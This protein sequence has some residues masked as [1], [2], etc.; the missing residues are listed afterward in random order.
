MLKTSRK[1]TNNTD[2]PEGLVPSLMPLKFIYDMFM[3]A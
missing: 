1:V 2:E 3:L